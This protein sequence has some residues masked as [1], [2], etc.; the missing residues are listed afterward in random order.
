MVTVNI[1]YISNEFDTI[2]EETRKDLT[3]TIWMYYVNMGWPCEKKMLP[4]ELHLY[5]NLRKDL[6]V[7]DGLVIKSS[8][9][10]IPSTLHWKVMKQI[11]EGH[12][13]MEKCMLKERESVVWP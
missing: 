9:L 10:V 11:H 13:C 2:H 3:L 5:W 4:Q 7:E 6:S 12:Q 8:R 1:P